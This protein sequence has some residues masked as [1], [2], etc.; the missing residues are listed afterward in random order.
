MR[1]LVLASRSASRRDILAR[2]GF[3]PVVDPADVDEE[4]D[5]LPVAARALELARRKAEAVAPRH[6]DALVLG[7]DSLLD[8]DGAPLGKPANVAAARDN[9]RRLGGRSATLVTGHYV[10]DTASGAGAGSAVATRVDFAMPEP[11]E[12]EAYLATR[13]SLFAA[14]GFTLEG[15]GSPFVAG[16]VG[17]AMSV[18]G[19]SP[20]AL[21]DLAASLGILLEELWPR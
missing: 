20:S 7:C 15:F 13:E 8:V 16:V 19:V 10:V 18:M 6:R 1:T 12:L 21:R 11:H 17:D 4:S 3:A 5:I 2:A 14:G 9:W